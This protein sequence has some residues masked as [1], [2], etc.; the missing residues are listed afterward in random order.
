MYAAGFNTPISEDSMVNVRQPP[1]SKTVDSTCYLLSAYSCKSY[2]MEYNA[3]LLA[4]VWQSI[5][6]YFLKSVA[7]S[8]PAVLNLILIQ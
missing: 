7:I 1:P 5:V 3:Y 6:D 2:R 4:I 8:A